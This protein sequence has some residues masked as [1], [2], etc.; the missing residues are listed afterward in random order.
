MSIVK[1]RL[2]HLAEPA[3]DYD[4]VALTGES[5][6]KHLEMARR[7]YQSC[8]RKAATLDAADEDPSKIREWLKKVPLSGKVFVL[9]IGF[10]EGIECDYDDFVSNYDD[11]WYPASDDMWIT[12]TDAT[13]LLEMNHEEQFNWRT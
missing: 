11:L 12:N 7:L 6:G 5:Y 8:K 4:S 9:W 3:F 10:G 2:T 13:I 1:S